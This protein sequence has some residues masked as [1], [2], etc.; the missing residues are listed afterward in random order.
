MDNGFVLFDG[1]DQRIEALLNIE[2]AENDLMGLYSEL[3][4]ALKEKSGTGAGIT[5]LSEYVFFQFIKRSLEEKIGNLF[6]SEDR[7][8]IKIFRTDRLLLTH[9]TNIARFVNV[10]YQRTDIALFSI[11]VTGEYK[12]L[13]AFEIKAYISDPKTLE[14]LFHRFKNVAENT[15]S[16]MFPV[17]FSK[18]YKN[19][20]EDFCSSYPGRAFIISNKEFNC[21]ISINQAIDK[22][23]DTL[24]E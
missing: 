19:K 11:K 20:I 21:Q 22:I 14:N 23:L 18:E 8:D 3:T 9:D 16:L 4:N 6:R 17:L 7:K 5:G 12:L 10:E 1:L 13:A 15:T 24:T 2:N